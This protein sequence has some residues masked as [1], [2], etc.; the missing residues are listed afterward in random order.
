[1]NKGRTPFIVATCLLVISGIFIQH[2]DFSWHAISLLLLASAGLILSG[3]I[4]YQGIQKNSS[5][6]KSLCFGGKQG[7]C[8]DIINSPAAKVFPWLSWGEI[9]L[10]YFSG[11][12]LLTLLYYGSP[13]I[14]QALAWLSAL[15]IP[16]IIY[17]VSYQAFVAKKWCVMCS[18]VM[19][20]LLLEF[21]ALYNQLG[22]PIG[23]LHLSGWFYIAMSFAIPV[24]TWVIIRPLFAA[25]T[26]L[27]AAKKT[28]S[29]FKNNDA[30]FKKVLS[31]QP[32]YGLPNPDYSIVLGNP[33]SKNIITIVSNPYCNPCSEAHK[34]LDEWLSVTDDLQVRVILTKS[35]N[36][37]TAR[38]LIALNNKGD[39]RLIKQAFTDWHKQSKKDY[40]TWAKKYPVNLDSEDCDTVI[41]QQ[42]EWCETAN[43]RFTPLVIVNGHQLPESY[44]IEDLKYLI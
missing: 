6:V 20:V 33:A 25:S 5:L 31:E 14:P 15:C 18:A 32:S 30:L 12:F 44:L 10:F 39:A 7:D 17:S 4:V 43:V 40:P 34:D 35:A 37:P 28:L 3:L 19:G 22:N 41:Q 23:S 26:E 11:T 8:D 29:K 38:H 42:S 36:D 16:Y 2:R 9:G 13:G 27:S 21:V 1:L 24:A